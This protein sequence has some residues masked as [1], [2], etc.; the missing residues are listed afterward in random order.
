MPLRLLF[1]CEN[2]GECLRFQEHLKR[3]GCHL[4]VAS[5]VEHAVRIALSAYYVDAI[6]IHENDNARGST[7]GS[8]LKLI[9]P[10]TPVL[11]LTAQWPSNGALP[12]GVDALCYASSFGRR[13][14]HDITKFVSHLL[15]QDPPEPLVEISSAGRRFVPQRPTYLN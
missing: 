11:L 8:G 6:L 4:L 9:C 3:E 13:A 12:F 1:V 14:A 10:T 15:L 5:D 2:S 7:V